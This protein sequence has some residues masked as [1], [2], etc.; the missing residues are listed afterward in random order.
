MA[1]ERCVAECVKTLLAA[2]PNAPQMGKDQLSEWVRLLAD[3]PDD[4]LR[5]GTDQIASTATYFPSVAELRRAAGGPGQTD[6]LARWRRE[7]LERAYAGDL[8][9]GDWARFVQRCESLGR[10]ELVAWAH[11]WLEG[12]MLQE[13]VELEAVA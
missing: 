4:R 7:L 11:R 12:W 2:F 8:D 6:E 10:L 13:G 9:L 1:T 5:M 3:V